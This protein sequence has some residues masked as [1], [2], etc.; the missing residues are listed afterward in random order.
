MAFCGRV[1][2]YPKRS[3]TLL[4]M[5]MPEQEEATQKRDYFYAALQENKSI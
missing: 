5:L 1:Y 3:G 2:I 4:W